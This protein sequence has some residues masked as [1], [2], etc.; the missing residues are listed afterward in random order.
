MAH[1]AAPFSLRLEKIARSLK[2]S[3]AVITSEVGSSHAKHKGLKTFSSWAMGLQKLQAQKASKDTL[4][5]SERRI[6]K[7]RND[8]NTETAGQTGS[9]EKSQTAQSFGSVHGCYGVRACGVRNPLFGTVFTD[10]FAGTS[11]WKS[12]RRRTNSSPVISYPGHR[13]GDKKINACSKSVLARRIIRNSWASRKTYE[14]GSN[15]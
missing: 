12:I 13:L 10:A 4:R 14:L 15:A 11:D 2:K 1:Q 3:A 5:D 7:D 9:K 8:L 6:R